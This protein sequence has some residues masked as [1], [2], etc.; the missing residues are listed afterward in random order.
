MGAAVQLTPRREVAALRN[1]CAFALVLTGR[2]YRAL[3]L[4]LVVVAT[5]PAAGTWSSFVVRTGS[6]EP[7]IHVGDVVI[8][9][10]F[11]AD[12]KMPVGRVM[13]F[14]APPGSGAGSQLRVHRVV[15]ALGHD[16]YTTAGD[17]NPTP[18]AAPVPRAN[19]RS[20][21]IIRVP[22]VGRP[23]VWLDDGQYGRLLAWLLLTSLLL[24]A[25]SRRVDGDPPRD[26]GWRG[27][28]A[29]RLADL[30][31][32][33]VGR[34][35]RPITVGL[36]V[37]AVLGVVGVTLAVPASVQA[38]FSART[39]SGSNAWRTATNLDQA[40]TAAVTADAPYALYLLDDASGVSAADAT[41]NSRTG[42]YTSVAGYQQAGALAHNFGYAVSLAANNG[43]IV[44]GGTGLTDPTTFSVEMWFR[45]TT[46]GGGKL[47]GFENSR[48]A[49]S[50]LFDRELFMRTD[51][52]LVYMGASSTSKLLVSPTP[53]NNGAWHQVVVTSV[54][55]GS[56]ETSVMYVDGVAVATGT[57]SRAATSYVGW[58][59]VGFGR[60]PVGTG[61]PTTGNFTGTVDNVA[62]YTTQL[63]A[64]RV[65]AHYTVR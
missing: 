15:E 10:P 32:L 17:A 26:S 40:Y 48:N 47:I 20:R 5:L 54:P 51:G 39:T 12:E 45:T 33:P 63:T 7:S 23:L 58:W 8:A 62:I 41:G 30:A 14:R 53:L 65:A 60:V 9:Q 31:R 24:S 61:Y 55:S 19:F 43:R 22:Y 59:R 28:L 13:I 38:A 25:S 50:T 21:A 34:H 2:T 27:G 57:T 44:G 3:L 36:R 64:T 16:T 1:W 18:D 49:T 46:S 11:G 4:T 52:R 6:M 56:Q 29:R 35:R 42:T 37:A